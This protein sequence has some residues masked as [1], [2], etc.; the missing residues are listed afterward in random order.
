MANTK[1][2]AKKATGNFVLEKKPVAVET[3]FTIAQLKENS[4]SIFGVQSEVVDG[5]LF[6]YKE[7]QITKTEASNL[8]KKFLQKVVK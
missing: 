8:I 6:D 3:K 2:A 7:K 1:Q 5:A 4:R